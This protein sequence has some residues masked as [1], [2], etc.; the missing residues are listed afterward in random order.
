MNVFSK[1]ERTGS[2]YFEECY[3]G[4]AF[5]ASRINN[6]YV[7]QRQDVD[8]IQ[9]KPYPVEH[10]EGSVHVYLQ[11]KGKCVIDTLLSGLAKLGQ[12]K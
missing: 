4:C 2:G 5:L 12:P 9:S 10:C 7:T 11:K 3:F 6:R 8:R 1:Y